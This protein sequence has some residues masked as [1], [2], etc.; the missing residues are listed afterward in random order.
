MKQEKPAR[1]GTNFLGMAKIVRRDASFKRSLSVSISIKK[2]ERV[3]YFA[4]SLRNPLLKEA[5]NDVTNRLLKLKGS[6]SIALKKTY[7]R[8]VIPL[9]F[10]TA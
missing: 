5:V 9:H 1:V 6:L 2:Y 8:P 4:R 10:A 7:I 3:V